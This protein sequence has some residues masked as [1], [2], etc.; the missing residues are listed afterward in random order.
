MVRACTAS[1]GG[2]GLANAADAGFTLSTNV[3]SATETANGSTNIRQV[4]DN[5]SQCA[6]AGPITGIKVD[7]KAPTVSCGA[8]DDAWHGG[9]VAIPCTASDAGSGVSNAADANF[10]L[11]TAGH[12]AQRR[13]TP[14]RTAGWCVTT[15]VR[16]VRLVR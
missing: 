11:T 7:L 8:A 15:W 14:R 6:I 16:A 12:S 13:Q 3:L 4:C 2:A 9:G 10:N 1:D 5:L